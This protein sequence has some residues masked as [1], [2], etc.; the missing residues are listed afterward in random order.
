M[1]HLLACVLTSLACLAQTASDPR[2]PSIL[3]EL[4][5]VRNFEQVAM[6]PD[7]KRV[8][9]IE[10]WSENGIFIV[11]LRAGSSPVGI[12]SGRDLAWSPDS[13]RV[14]FLSDRDRKGQMQLYVAP[15]TGGA[16]RKL[17]SLTGYLTDPLWSPDGTQIA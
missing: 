8:A 4:A 15:A 5:S 6:S 7:A 1:R 17:T 16:A 2:I 9:W 11:D 13:S 10:K 12:G 14:A 3:G